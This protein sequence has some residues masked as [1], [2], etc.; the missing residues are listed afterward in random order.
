MACTL[1]PTLQHV[2]QAGLQLENALNAPCAGEM[3]CVDGAAATWVQ[4]AGVPPAG[5]LFRA[6]LKRE[7]A[8]AGPAARVRAELRSVVTAKA[9]GRLQHRRHVRCAPSP[10]R[11]PFFV[12]CVARAPLMSDL[13]RRACSR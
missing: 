7:R 11:L 2:A 9:L 13:E 4:A 12:C 6:L 8:A 10:V 5:G 1:H 3:R